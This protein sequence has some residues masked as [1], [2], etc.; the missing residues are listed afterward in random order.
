MLSDALGLDF[1]TSPDGIICLLVGAIV[2]VVATQMLQ[3]KGLGL[4]GSIVLGAVG[5]V[6]SGYLFDLINIMDV[7]DYADPIIAA[8]I[9][10]VVVLGVASLLRR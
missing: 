7:G 3:G 10:S 4:V 1:A 9:G 2:G 5:G 8:V 6:I